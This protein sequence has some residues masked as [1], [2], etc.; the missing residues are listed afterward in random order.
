MIHRKYRVRDCFVSIDQRAKP[1][2]ACV[3]FV[4]MRRIVF[5]RSKYCALIVY[6]RYRL[7]ASTLVYATPRAIGSSID[8]T[9]AENIL[10]RVRNVSIRFNRKGGQDKKGKQE[11]RSLRARNSRTYT[12][13][14]PFIGESA[15]EERGWPG[16]CGVAEGLRGRKGERRTVVFHSHYRNVLPCALVA[17]RNKSLVTV[18]AVVLGGGAGGG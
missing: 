12:R 8:G 6:E 9:F 7:R 17:P 5:F 10:P 11:A 15:G 1:R 4:S 16:S 13:P 2:I 3:C 14:G 18:T